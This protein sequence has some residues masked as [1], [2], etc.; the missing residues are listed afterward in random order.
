MFV[1]EASNIGASE[2]VRQ[3]EN[4]NIQSMDKAMLDDLKKN[5]D[6]CARYYKG[7][8]LKVFAWVFFGC[9]VL[10]IALLGF[11]LPELH[12]N[13]FENYSVEGVVESCVIKDKIVVIKLVQDDNEYRVNNIVFDNLSHAFE[14]KIKPSDE[15]SLLV[16]YTDDY[17][18]KNISQ[19][20]INGV[21][22]LD[23]QESEAA[24]TDNYNLGVVMVIVFAAIGGTFTVIWIVCLIIGKK[25]FSSKTFDSSALKN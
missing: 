22:Y 23:A 15:I 12:I 17:G 20:E 8:N 1:S 10:F 14:G 5:N 19:I 16:A 2:L 18:R 25:K 3:F 7:I 21:K 4:E 11:I 24:E 9:G 6:V 13:T